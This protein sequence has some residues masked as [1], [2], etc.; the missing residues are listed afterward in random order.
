MRLMFLILSLLITFSSFA[1]EKKSY[2]HGKIFILKLKKSEPVKL[3]FTNNFLH[4]LETKDGV[5][6]VWINSEKP[7]GEVEKINKLKPNLY[8]GD[9]LKNAFRYRIDCKS[10]KVI[11]SEEIK[12][13]K[14]I[15][16]SVEKEM[17]KEKRFFYDERCNS[18][19]FPIVE[20]GRYYTKRWGF[21]V[22]VIDN[23]EIVISYTTNKIEK[24]EVPVH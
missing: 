22:S 9:V 2:L 24:R 10:G 3:P 4:L 1:M 13:F 15:K 6:Y 19:V 12:D 17:C 21:T 16:C 23:D 14:D 20:F 8:I 18:K 7:L 11:S 5:A